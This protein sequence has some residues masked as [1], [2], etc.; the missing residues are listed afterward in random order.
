[1]GVVAF[2]IDSQKQLSWNFSVCNCCCLCLLLMLPC[3]HIRLLIRTKLGSF[4]TMFEKK[5]M[6]RFRED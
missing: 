3:R 5:T 6:S 4:F 2:S 1:M